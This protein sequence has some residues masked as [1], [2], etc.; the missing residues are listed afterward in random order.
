MRA[1]LTPWYAPWSCGGSSDPRTVQT[2][3][4]HVSTTWTMVY[5]QSHVHSSRHVSSRSRAARL[6]TR[7]EKPTQHGGRSLKRQDAFRKRPSTSDDDPVLEKKV[8]VSAELPRDK[9]I[10]ACILTSSVMAVLGVGASYAGAPLLSVAGSS[11]RSIAADSLFHVPAP[12]SLLTAV[13]AGALV[14]ATRFALMQVWQD[15]KDS[16]D[17]ANSQVLLPPPKRRSHP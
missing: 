4:A 1:C 12:Q 15:L 17:A 14:T 7:A 11:I 6:V 3:C 13:A 5:P 8:S 10:E 9:V 16:T 2:S